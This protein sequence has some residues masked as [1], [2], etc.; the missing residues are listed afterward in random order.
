MIHPVTTQPA[1]YWHVLALGAGMKDPFA[2]DPA[3]LK[4]EG[5]HIWVDAKNGSDTHTGLWE[6]V[7]V[8]TMMRAGEVLRLLPDDDRRARGV[9][10]WLRAS[11]EGDP[12]TYYRDYLDKDG[13][14]YNVQ[15]SPF[16]GQNNY[17]IA[18]NP[19][20]AALAIFDGSFYD[21]SSTVYKNAGPRRPQSLYLQ[22]DDVTL[23]RLRFRG[24]AGDCVYFEGD[25]GHF[26]GLAFSRNEATGLCLRGGA[27]LAEYCYAHHHDSPRNRGYI[28]TGIKAE[29][30]VGVTIRY[31]VAHN[32]GFQNIDTH[33]SQDVLI[34]GCDAFE[35]GYQ[36]GLAVRPHPNEYA[37][38]FALGSPNDKVTDTRILCVAN[39]AWKA[40][41]A[42]FTTERNGGM[43]LLYNVS[44]D[45]DR[46]GY[47][48][49]GY[50]NLLANN[51]SE[52]DLE[53]LTKD[54]GGQAAIERG[55][56]WNYT[57]NATSDFESM[58][59]L[60]PEPGVDD[61]FLMPRASVFTDA[62]PYDAGFGRDVGPTRV[63]RAQLRGLTPT[64]IRARI[65]A[66]PV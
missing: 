51:I 22:G 45:G 4:H 36:G 49:E 3:D 53:L 52:S 9:R 15:Q 62:S 63:V 14:S 16:Q 5:Y 35:A 50:P 29:D 33:R 21:R 64:E 43:R 39:R 48:S 65:R 8:Q 40:A 31:C 26:S 7:P 19:K 34:Y 23:K 54:G 10:I 41:R 57:D 46:Y 11:K 18:T 6:T 20:D 17:W 12:A 59:S 30:S 37:F 13:A 60:I 1:F 55:N 38:N 42:N 44:Y 32:N 56:N 24:V 66:V 25:R 28:A 58:T 27:S 61:R 2:A 47:V